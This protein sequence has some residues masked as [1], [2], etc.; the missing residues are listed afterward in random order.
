MYSVK[1]LET[2][3]YETSALPLAFYRYRPKR[4][5]ITSG[6][7]RGGR[8]VYLELRQSKGTGEISSLNYLSNGV[9]VSTKGDEFGG[10]CSMKYNTIR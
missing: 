2:E 1:R 4:R 5:N 9:T 10:K 6:D 7:F 3:M 8:Y